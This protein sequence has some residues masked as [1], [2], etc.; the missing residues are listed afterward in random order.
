MS[1]LHLADDHGVRRGGLCD[2]L[3]AHAG[4]E[5]CESRTRTQPQLHE[6][7]CV[8]FSRERETVQLL[9]EGKSSKEVA[10]ILDLRLN[11]V[12]T[13]RSNI[14]RKFGVH[15]LSELVLDAFRHHIV[16]IPVG[17]K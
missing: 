8:V 14:M 15:S 3:K 13:H 11:R 5:A 7:R 6:P 17:P 1:A 16:Q 9:A 4:W 12:D 10:S 2:L